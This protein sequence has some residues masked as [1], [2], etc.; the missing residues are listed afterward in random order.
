MK[1]IPLKNETKH[2]TKLEELFNLFCGLRELI[3]TQTARPKTSTRIIQWTNAMGKTL[4]EYFEEFPEPYR[5]QAINN[6]KAQRTKGYPNDEYFLKFD[7]ARN[8]KEA[9]AGAFYF[10]VTPE[11]KE[12]WDDFK[13][14]L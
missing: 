9:L 1:E 13:R 6:T 11:G 10:E 3:T 8:A 5:T 12:Y 14:T 4:R 7:R 2:S